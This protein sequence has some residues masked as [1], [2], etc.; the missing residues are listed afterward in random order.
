[1]EEWRKKRGCGSECE[2]GVGR[3]RMRRREVEE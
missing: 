2:E 3:R 1:M